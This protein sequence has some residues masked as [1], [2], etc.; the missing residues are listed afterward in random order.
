MCNHPECSEQEYPTI[1]KFK[2]NASEEELNILREQMKTHVGGRV[3]LIPNT[4]EVQYP[5]Y[6]QMLNELKEIRE[7]LKG[8]V[9]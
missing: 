1:V 5:I 6:E 8:E 2:P 7:I 4:M 3:M 9:M